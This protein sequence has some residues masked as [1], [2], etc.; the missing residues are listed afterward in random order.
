M[1]VIRIW[2]LI[3]NVWWSLKSCLRNM[4]V[5][6]NL[7]ISTLLKI[8]IIINQ[9]LPMITTKRKKPKTKETKLLKTLESTNHQ[10]QLW[11]LQMSL[12]K[13]SYNKHPD[14][15]MHQ[16]SLIHQEICWV[17][18]GWGS[19]TQ[20]KI[21]LNKNLNTSGTKWINHIAKLCPIQLIIALHFEDKCRNIMV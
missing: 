14:L 1:E 7:E 5:L 19:S 15:I 20:V 11:I 8:G 13:I 2:N 12:V 6:K 9:L 16:S 21:L 4:K 10:L 3:M 17:I 18:P